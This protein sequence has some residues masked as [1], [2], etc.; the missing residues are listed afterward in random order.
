MKKILLFAVLALAL[1]S[2]T[3]KKATIFHIGQSRESVVNTIISDFKVNG[4][5][6]D[7]EKV[8]E[9]E[10]GNV[11]TLYECEYKGQYYRKVRVYYDNEKVSQMQLKTPKDKYPNLIT[12]LENEYGL[13]HKTSIPKYFTREDAVVFMGEESAVVVFEYKGEF[14]IMLVSGDKKEQLNKLM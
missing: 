11:I 12:D 7:K 13:P 1:T 9:E 8:L 2:C 14:E 6:I 4:T 5:H 10:N 3:T